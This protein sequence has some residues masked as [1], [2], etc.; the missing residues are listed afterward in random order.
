[1]MN[2]INGRARQRG[3]TLIE[4][5]LVITIIGILAAVVVP[6]MVGRGEEARM[7]AAKL[8]LE[9]LGLALDT[10]ELDNGRFPSTDEGLPVLFEK[11]AALDGWKGPYLKKRIAR[12][13]WGSPYVYLRPGIHNR[14]YDLMSYGPN[15]AEGGGDDIAN[16]EDAK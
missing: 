11:P 1:M 15:K 5:M 10:F 13:P 14:D 4:I 6:R 16:W 9:N 2:T 7:S 3:F 8:Q 12:D